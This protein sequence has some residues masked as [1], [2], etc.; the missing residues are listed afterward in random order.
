METGNLVH[1]LEFGLYKQLWLGS[2]HCG[3]IFIY[4]LFYIYASTFPGFMM[5]FG[6]NSFLI[7]LIH[8][9]LV[10]FFEYGKACVFITPIPCSAETDPLY[11]AD[12]AVSEPI[13]RR[14]GAFYVP[15]NSYT[16]GSRALSISG[17]YASATTFRCKLPGYFI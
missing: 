1:G 9:I 16:N 11:L 14:T 8:S 5:P 15:T 4:L 7:F 3:Q 13:T 17:V 12:Y 10:S 6:S 2:S